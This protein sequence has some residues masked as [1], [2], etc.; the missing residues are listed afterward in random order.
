MLSHA[1][2]SSKV[3]FKGKF[4][5][6]A[7]TLSKF[8][9][10]KHHFLDTITVC[11]EGLVKCLVSGRLEYFGLTCV[12]QNCRHAGWKGPLEVTKRGLLFKYNCHQHQIRSPWL[13]LAES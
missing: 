3:E 11:E 9:L 12:S 5:T 4:I 1:K 10:G 2:E 13:Y 6:P 7:E 8:S